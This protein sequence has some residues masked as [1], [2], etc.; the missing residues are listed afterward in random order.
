MRCPLV[1]DSNRCPNDDV[2]MG[3]SSN[4]G[5]ATAMHVAAVP[6]IQG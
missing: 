2:N 4:D 3:L 1:V 6:E 5:F